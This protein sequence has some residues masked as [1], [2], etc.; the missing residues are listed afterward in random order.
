MEMS[1]PPTKKQK[2]TGA[3]A[4]A[5]AGAGEAQESRMSHVYMVEWRHKSTIDYFGSNC[6]AGCKDKKSKEAQ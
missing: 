6:F 5:G 3:G 4:G 1:A 2:T